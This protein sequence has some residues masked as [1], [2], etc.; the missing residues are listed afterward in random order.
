MGWLWLL[1]HD[2]HPHLSAR[3][4]GTSL[5]VQLHQVVSQ[6]QSGYFRH[7]EHWPN[8]KGGRHPSTLAKVHWPSR[9]RAKVVYMIHIKVGWKWLISHNT[10]GWKMLAIFWKLTKI[11]FLKIRY[12]VANTRVVATYL[13]FQLLS[14]STERFKQ[15]AVSFFLSWTQNSLFTFVQKATFLS[16]TCKIRVEQCFQK[17]SNTY[18]TKVL[19]TFSTPLQKV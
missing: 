16:Q 9:S 14:S 8:Q 19:R 3:V 15:K 12:F 10:A 6:P 4:G 11:F 17:F 2:S 13:L 5:I 1:R 7:H 18:W